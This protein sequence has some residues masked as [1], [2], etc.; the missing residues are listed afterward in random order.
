MKYV[1]IDLHKHF[2]H[3]AVINQNNEV[4]KRARVASRPEDILKFFAEFDGPVRAAVEA[5]RN[6][7]WFYDLVEPLVESLQLVS[8]HK[9][10]VIAE[11]TV[12]TDRI[13]ARV[14]AELL[15]AN[16]L[17]TCY[18]PPQEVRQLRELLRQ[19]AFVVTLRTKVKNRVH[20]LL[21]KLGIEHPFDNLFSGR[22]LEFLKSLKLDGAYQ[23]ELGQCLNL[24]EDLDKLEKASWRVIRKLSQDSKEATLLMTIPGIGHHNALLILAEIGDVSRFSSGEKLASYCGLIPSVHISERRVRYGQMTQQGNRWLRWVYVEAAHV[25]RKKSLRLANLYQRVAAKKGPQKAIGAVARELAV[26]S[27]YVLITREPFRDRRW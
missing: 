13:D 2:T 26:I 27:Y 6:W 1:G 15:R 23:W 20:G 12:K 22:G 10:R 4:V 16:Y 24:L 7:Y 18:V 5:T 8:P 9:M 21:D 14:I 17:P 19:R 3:F 11:S 25:A